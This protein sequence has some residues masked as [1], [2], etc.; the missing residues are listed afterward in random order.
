MKQQDKTTQILEIVKRLGVLRPRDLDEYGIPRIYLRRLHDR[1]L[2][3]RVGR[4]LY[5][6]ADVEATEYHTFVKHASASHMA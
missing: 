6:L 3:R 1:Q 5:V 4:G 2:L